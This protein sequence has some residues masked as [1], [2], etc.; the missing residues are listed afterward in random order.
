VVDGIVD[1]WGI[2]KS[3]AQKKAIRV[4]AEATHG[5]RSV[6]DNLVVRH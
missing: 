2:T 1:L 4:A 6:N 5:V 3:E